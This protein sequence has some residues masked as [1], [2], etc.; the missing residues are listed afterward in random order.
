MSTCTS[1]PSGSD[2]PAGSGSVSDCSCSRGFTGPNGGPCAPSSIVSTSLAAFDAE[3]SPPPSQT[4]VP[5]DTSAESGTS[6]VTDLTNPVSITPL[7]A[8]SEDDAWQFLSDESRSFL[9]TIFSSCSLG[10]TWNQLLHLRIHSKGRVITG[11]LGCRLIRGQITVYVC[12]RY[13]HTH[14]L[15]LFLPPARPPSLPPSLARSLALSAMRASS[16]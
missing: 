16:P 8:P 7:A 1:C 6:A 3:I 11:G 10:L 13:T 14:S 9:S 2:S 15:S 12:D 5:S 4:L